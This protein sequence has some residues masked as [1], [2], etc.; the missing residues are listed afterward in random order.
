MFIRYLSCV[1]YSFVSWN[2]CGVVLG[3]IIRFVFVFWCEWGVV[4]LSW[5]GGIEVVRV[6]GFSVGLGVCCSIFLCV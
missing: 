4:F 2:L 3:G 1:E 6:L 5:W